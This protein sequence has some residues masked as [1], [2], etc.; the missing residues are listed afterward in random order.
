M[1]RTEIGQRIDYLVRVLSMSREAAGEQAR[2]ELANIERRM[3]EDPSQKLH[4][5]P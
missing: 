3:A 4:L 1:K 2:R 5:M